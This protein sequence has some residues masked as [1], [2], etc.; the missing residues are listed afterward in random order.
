MALLQLKNPFDGGRNWDFGAPPNLPMMMPAHAPGAVY[1]VSPVASPS[2]A[3]R[4]VSPMGP[5]VAYLPASP[6]ASPG[7]AYRSVSPI[8]GPGVA[9]LP[10]R[11]MA[12]P[13]VAYRSV[14]PMA[15]PGVAYR[16][17]SPMSSPGLAHRSAN[18]MADAGAR[19]G[20]SPRPS[21]RSARRSGS[22]SVSPAA[23]PSLR[24]R[25]VS[26]AGSLGAVKYRAGSGPNPAAEMMA[27]ALAQVPSQMRDPTPRYLKSQE[28]ATPL[29]SASSPTSPESQ[30]KTHRPVPAPLSPQSSKRISALSSPKSQ[31]QSL[32]R[33]FSG[34]ESESSLAPI[35]AGS[36][37][38]SP[39]HTFHR[40]FRDGTLP[41]PGGRSRSL[42]LRE[43]SVSR[44]REDVVKA[45]HRLS[46]A[47]TAGEL[48]TDPVHSVQKAHVAGP[49]TGS[50]VI[51]D[52]VVLGVKAW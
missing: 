35:H 41:M 26:G 39:H 22:R 38:G 36:E 6:M 16:S 21:A 51:E 48:E 23:S 11:P 9:Y 8:A 7:V 3:Y 4:S 15:S 32:R 31:S 19:D 10:A 30:E 29:T 24:S 44:E 1:H 2:V 45:S 49:H 14:S 20:V 43:R 25:E 47:S 28:A 13:G 27:A 12:S 50:R 37:P 33:S 18:L 42:Q 40:T 34:L 52:L 5:G 46:R 17:V